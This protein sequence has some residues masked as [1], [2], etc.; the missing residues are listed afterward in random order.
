MGSLRG[1]SYGEEFEIGKKNAF[2]I[3]EDDNLEQRLLKLL[4][5]RIDVALIGPGRS[6]FDNLIRND[7]KLLEK[8]DEFVVLPVPF[9][10]DPNYLGFLKTMNMQG[11]LKEFNKILQKG[12]ESGEI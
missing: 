11:F 8:K 1:A 6:G 2:E 12:Y 9:Y 4:R 10:R 7:N 5:K 3:D